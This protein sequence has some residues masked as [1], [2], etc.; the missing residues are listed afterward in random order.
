M[1]VHKEFPEPV[2]M[3]LNTISQEEI[4]KRLITENGL[5]VAQEEDILALDPNDTVGAMPPNEAI[6]YLKRLCDED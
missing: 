1:L 5:T 2:A 3:I 6:E 4:K